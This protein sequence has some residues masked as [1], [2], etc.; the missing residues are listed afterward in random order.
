[1]GLHSITYL[2]KSIKE[3]KLDRTKRRIDAQLFELEKK[4]NLIMTMAN[5][6]KDK[7][8]KVVISGGG[9]GGHVFPAIAIANSIKANYP[10]TEILFVGAHGRMEM[11]KVPEAGYS[12]KGLRI[13]GMQRGSF[14]KNILF[15]FKLAFSI[16]QA[17]FIVLKFK[18]DVAVG[19]GGYASGPLLYVAT[20]KNIPTLIQEQNSFPGITNKLLGEKVD[21]ICVAYDGMKK[22]FPSKK[23]ILTGN[24][25]RSNIQNIQI[26]KEQA[27]KFFSLEND[28]P[29]LLI[30]GGSLGAKAINSSIRGNL[31]LLTE[32]KIQVI[33][34]T[35]SDYFEKV[36]AR[37]EEY[38]KKGILVFEFIKDMDYAYAAADVIVS[39]AGAIALSEIT[40]VG[41]PAI[42]VPSP[43]VAED[44]QTK[45]AHT[46]VNQNAAVLVREKEVQNT[47]G[48]VIVNLMH[49]EAKQQQI[50][51]NLKKL[52]IHDSAKIIADEVMLLANKE[53]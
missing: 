21:V 37:K 23:I 31:E 4:H 44:H 20:K 47:L 40:L 26:T 30:I 42:I 10:N 9:T 18:P 19:V 2:S 5:M 7:K 41:K 43:Y 25:V 16:I 46:L 45:N 39:R 15:P 35:G 34:Q 11:E 27:Y 51:D 3:Q 50:K 29:V 13:S 1:M 48:H 24:P 6:S 38:A 14:W 8:F 52:A 49:D 28:K 36:K 22:Y 12:I 32:N 33:W 17:Y 53:K